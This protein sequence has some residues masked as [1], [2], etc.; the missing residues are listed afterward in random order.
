VQ[1]GPWSL[2]FRPLSLVGLVDDNVCAVG[3]AGADEDNFY[4]ISNN[5][6]QQ[7]AY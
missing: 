7:S 4:L 5:A 1:T 2:R 3:A 6:N